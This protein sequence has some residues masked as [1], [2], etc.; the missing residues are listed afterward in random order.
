MA[1]TG[2]AR[3][4]M[5]IQDQ[6]ETFRGFLTA[7]VWGGGLAIQLVALLTLAFAIGAGWWAGW[8]AFVAI[9][10]AAGF[11]FRMSSVYWAVQAAIW[12]V[13]ALGGFIVPALSGMMG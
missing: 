7:S 2:G 3:G 11:F 9:G 10:A 6:K 12:V 13:L 1:Q 8:I 5:D 4:N